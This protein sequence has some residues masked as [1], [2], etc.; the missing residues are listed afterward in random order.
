VKRI[1]ILLF[2]LGFTA[3]PARADGVKGVSGTLGMGAI[4]SVLCTLTVVYGSD[5]EDSSADAFDRRG[6]FIGAGASFAGE[7]F[8]DRPVLDI[9]DI[10]SNQP[11]R[12]DVPVLPGPATTASADNTWSVSGH[13]GYRCHPRFS[14]GATFEFFGGFDTQ[15]SGAW[16]MGGNDTDMF[17]ATS[18]IKGYLLTGRYQPYLLFGGGT[19]RISTK[20]TN[21]MGIVRPAPGKDPDRGP[22]IQSRDHTD[23][24]FR[25]GGG[26][27]VYATE[28]VVVNVGA[29]YLLPLGEVSGVDVYTV[30]GGVEY[31]F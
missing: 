30:G 29:S 14:V 16:G 19:M 12:D 4:S 1:A 3:T 27:D 10:F 26:F 13:G 17:V 21:P 23:F 20:V 24:V 28:H 22:V 25:F 8:S 9:A 31:R 7:N 18:D 11:G 15:W 2:A 6:F 5:D